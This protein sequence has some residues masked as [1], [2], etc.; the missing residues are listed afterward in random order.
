MTPLMENATS[1]KVL[2]WIE[3]I[4]LTPVDSSPL[5]PD[6]LQLSLISQGLWEHQ[7]SN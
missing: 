1:A 3:V 5:Y 4:V 7:H 6:L 2:K